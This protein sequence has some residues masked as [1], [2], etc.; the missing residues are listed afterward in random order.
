MHVFIYAIEIHRGNTCVYICVS[1]QVTHVR[2]LCPHARRAYLHAL[3]ESAHHYMPTLSLHAYHIHSER[4]H[5]HAS[6]MQGCRQ[7]ASHARNVHGGCL[8]SASNWLAFVGKFILRQCRCSYFGLFVCALCRDVA[9]SCAVVV[10]SC[11]TCMSMRAA[12]LSI[13]SGK[14]SR[15]HSEIQEA[16]FGLVFCGLCSAIS[17]GQLA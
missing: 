9:L 8:C 17:I 6:C 1:T 7:T 13:H 15:R 16:Q 12:Y 10:H 5:M 4:R 2:C 14:G 3:R 11:S